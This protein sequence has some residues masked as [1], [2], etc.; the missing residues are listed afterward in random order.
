MHAPRPRIFLLIIQQIV[1]NLVRALIS[2]IP[3]GAIYG[4]ESSSI[5][6]ERSAF[7]D[8]AAKQGG[9]SVHLRG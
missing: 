8:N 4:D 9:E 5:R 7:S 1:I 2:S 3:A 6:V